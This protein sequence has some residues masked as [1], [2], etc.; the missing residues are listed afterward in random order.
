MPESKCTIVK[1]S[2]FGVIHIMTTDRATSVASTLEITLEVIWGID[3][4]NSICTHP[5]IPDSLSSFICKV[6]DHDK[7][8]RIGSQGPSS[9]YGRL[10][11]KLLTQLANEFFY[12]M[13]MTFPQMFQALNFKAVLEEGTDVVAKMLQATKHLLKEEKLVHSYPY[14]WRTKKWVVIHACKKRLVRY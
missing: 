6:Y 5:I 1:C 3:L 13:K 11:C 2:S 14:D 9:W 10:Q 8:N 7:R 12:R 4:E